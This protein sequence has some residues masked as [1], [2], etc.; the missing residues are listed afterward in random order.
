MNEKLHH[1]Y[2]LY[3]SMM[4]KITQLLCQMR[5]DLYVLYYWMIWE[6]TG[7]LGLVSQHSHA[8]ETCTLQKIVMQDCMLHFITKFYWN[9]L[10]HQVY[11]PIKLNSL[12]PVHSSVC[13]NIHTPV[14]PYWGICVLYQ[15]ST[16]HCYL[17]II[18]S[19]EG[20][21]FLMFQR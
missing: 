15:N 2:F 4:K 18:V 3:Y 9:D 12:S 5:N 8:V 21:F 11:T 1:F 10:C 14:W 17:S 19:C 20:F 7:L 16:I 13:L 6:I